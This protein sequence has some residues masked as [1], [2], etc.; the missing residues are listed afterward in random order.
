MPR[1]RWTFRLLKTSTFRLA[2][3]YLVVFAISVGAVLGYVYWQTLKLLDEQADETIAAEVQ[4]I[5]EQYALN[6]T[7]GVLA[8]IKNRTR[9]DTGGLYLLATPVGKRLGGNLKSLPA[10]VLNN[11]PGWIEFAYV[12]ETPRG[13]TEHKARGFYTRL[14]GG[15]HL[16]VGRDIQELRQFGKIIRNTLIWALGLT[17][18]LGIGGGLLLSRNFLRRIDAITATVR[19]IRSGRMSD[20]VPLEG[21]GDELDRLAAALN[22]MLDEIERLM[23]GMKEVS[24]NI[25]HDLRTP[26]NRLRAQAEDALRSDD[27][28]EHRRALEATIEHADN[29]LKTFNALLFIARAEAGQAAAGFSELDAAEVVREIG[30]LYQP[31]VEDEGGSLKMTAP[32]TLRM[33][34]DRQLIAQAL[35]NLL[36]NALKYGRRDDEPP[37]ITIG[38]EVCDGHICLFVADRGPGIPESETEH[39]K[40][41]FVRLDE[42]RSAPGSGLGLSLV[43]SIARLHGGELILRDNKPG[44]RAILKLPRDGKT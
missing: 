12:V 2:A 44:L 32:E 43:T 40:D 7:P 33:R 28:A 1:A 5:A 13:L 14:E 15:Y 34:G 20:R 10:N 11:E 4:G 21:S 27:P 24:S 35:V 38:A 31:I 23:R 22:D 8:V 36:D 42:S 6:G 17:A 18:I 39:V 3:V 30:E 16:L 26:L 37:Q 41:R 19:A 25:A 9:L 29:L